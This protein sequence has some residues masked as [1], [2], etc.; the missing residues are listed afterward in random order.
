MFSQSAQ[1]TNSAAFRLVC[2]GLLVAIVMSTIV[3]CLAATGDFF[4]AGTSSL[5]CRARV[6]P[7]IHLAA[8]IPILL[9]GFGLGFFTFAGRDLP[10][11]TRVRGLCV[12]FLALIACASSLESFA[13]QSRQYR[14]SCIVGS[15]DLDLPA[16]V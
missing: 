8:L 11:G 6:L 3:F 4:Q 13:E 14:Q 2:G 12:C 5:E 15:L 7:G 16:R 9:G 10:G 1:A